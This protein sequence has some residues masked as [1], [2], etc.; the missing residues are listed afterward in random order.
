MSE[1][2]SLNSL[3][4]Q[5]DNLRVELARLVERIETLRKQQAEEEPLHATS[6]AEL[7]LHENAVDEKR[8]LLG[9]LFEKYQALV[10]E[11][12]RLRSLVEK[13]P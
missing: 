7:A 13:L 12:R 2:D 5:R 3:R 6:S 4:Q 9:E 1:K 11:E 8:V 10:A